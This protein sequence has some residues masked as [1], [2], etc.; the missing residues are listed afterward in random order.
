MAV[1]SDGGVW[2]S[3]TQVNTTASVF[4]LYLSW[5]TA[6]LSAEDPNW[7]SNVLFL[8][9]GAKYQT[10]EESQKHMKLLGMQV[11]ISS[12]YSYSTAPIGKLKMLNTYV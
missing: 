12:P 4:C 11:C 7:K 5:L 9:D 10:C 3:L 8:I 1:D 2:L 6:K